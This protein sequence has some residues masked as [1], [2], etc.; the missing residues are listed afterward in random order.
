MRTRDVSGTSALIRAEVREFDPDVAMASFT[1]MAQI[2]EDSIAE[3]RFAAKLLSGFAALALLLAALGIYG[4]L[5][6]AVAQR[7][8]EF[9]VRMALGATAAN[10]RH[11]VLWESGVSVLI[12]AALGLV[13]A[14]AI[15]RVMSGLL[16]GVGAADPTTFGGVIAVL[17]LA[18]LAASW[19]PAVRATRVDPVDAMRPE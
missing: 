15:T 18:A 11:M 16:F 9:G 8:R 13:G 12:G 2:F 10:V 4:V 14:L 1:T 7:T 5:S 17:G 19:L 3:R 6:Y